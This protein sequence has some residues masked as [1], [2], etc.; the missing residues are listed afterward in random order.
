M[1]FVVVHDSFNLFVFVATFIM[2]DNKVKDLLQVICI[3][4]CIN[5]FSSAFDYSLS[6]EFVGISDKLNL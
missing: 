5:C 2:L 6:V 3:F 4:L 1:F